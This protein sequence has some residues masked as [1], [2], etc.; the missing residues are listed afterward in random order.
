MSVTDLVVKAYETVNALKNA[1]A[2]LEKAELQG[3]IADLTMQLAE[4]K[5]AAADLL[6]ENADLKA[7]LADLRATGEMPLREGDDG[8]YY[9]GE[10]GPYCP[11]CF[12]QNKVLQLVTKNRPPID[13][14]CQY[15]CSRCKTQ[16][17]P[18]L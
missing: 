10:K 12:G 17:N 14:V 5:I 9:N 11:N 16:F 3:K 6:S 13:Q 8:F 2:T 1:V 4:I 7:E 15:R 18:D